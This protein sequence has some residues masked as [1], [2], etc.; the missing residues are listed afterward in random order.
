MQ[1]WFALPGRTAMSR[2]CEMNAALSRTSP[3]SREMGLAAE[4]ASQRNG[5]EESRV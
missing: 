5:A 4:L 3:I 1:P 2:A